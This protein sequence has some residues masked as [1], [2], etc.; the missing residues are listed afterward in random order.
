M[1]G[2]TL[3]EY[4]NDWIVG[5]T[6]ITDYVKELYAYKLEQKDITGLLPKEKTYLI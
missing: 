3:H 1:K 6:D 4:V 5:L 2:Q